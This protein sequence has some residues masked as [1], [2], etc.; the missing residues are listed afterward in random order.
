MSSEM[1]RA[2]GDMMGVCKIVNDSNTIESDLFCNRNV[3]Q[4]I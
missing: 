4:R 1:Y 3:V 2:S